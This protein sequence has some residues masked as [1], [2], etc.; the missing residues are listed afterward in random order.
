MWVKSYSKVFQGVTKKQIWRRW[1]DINSWPEWDTDLEVA[2][3]NGPFEV[4]QTFVF[5]PKGS[6]PVT[7]TLVNVEKYKTFTDCT[8]FPGATM[9]GT[10]EM[11]EED[12]ALRLTTTM[13]VT[14]ILGFIWRK[15]VAQNIVDTLD[16]QTEA[17]V[18]AA[19]KHG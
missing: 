7:L 4:G 10:H 9:Y 5:K 16:E 14:G 12:G 1:S 18:N 13:R 15:L 11:Q 3:A 2:H 17:L 6:R 8:R 19:K